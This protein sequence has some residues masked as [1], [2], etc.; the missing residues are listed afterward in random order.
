[1]VTVNVPLTNEI[2]KILKKKRK[3]FRVWNAKLVLETYLKTLPNKIIFQ[4]KQKI[5]KIWLIR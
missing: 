4:T 3:I 5:N 1:M 2:Y